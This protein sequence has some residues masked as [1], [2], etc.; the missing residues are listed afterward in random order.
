MNR[1]NFL[2]NS[3]LTG[4]A[5]TTG[6]AFT[7][8]KTE[9][10]GKSELLKR[11]DFKL[12]YAPHFGMFE[13]HAGRDLMDQLEFMSD[14]G[15]RG[16]EDNGMKGRNRRTQEQIGQK[17]SDLGMDMGVFVAHTIYWNEPSLSTGDK[18]YL[19]KFLDEIRESIEV[20]ERVNA[21]WMTVVP[22]HVDLR[23]DMDYQELNV[24][25][26]LKRAAEILEP[27]DLVM[28]LEPLNTLH[29]HP[30]M[31][32]TKTSQANRICKHVGS[33]S[34]KILYDAYHQA[35]TEGNMIPNIDAAWDEIP[36]FQLGDHPGRNEPW[37]G[38]IYYRNIFKH[39]YDKGFDGI[40]GM[41]HGKSRDGKEGELTL[42]DA[43]VRAD[44]FEI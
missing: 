9:I 7:N 10:P 8:R 26:A 30:G 44:D 41:E 1:K 5:L 42:I 19:D 38:E 12:K 23:L 32:L 17:L 18:D 21:K 34:C 13:N 29:N 11:H 33:P 39:I 31:I 16:L 22:G 3:L 25:D 27:H 15:F 37:T 4:T 36:Y 43:Y 14:I 28:V 20:A 35:I 40:V 24:I 2:K 6:T